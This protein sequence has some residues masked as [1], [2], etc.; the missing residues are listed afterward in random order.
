MS[1]TVAPPVHP[2]LGVIYPI[3]DEAR[4]HRARHVMAI[5]R[6][7]LGWTFLWAFLDK[8]FGFGYATE[9]ADA[10]LN[11]GSPTFGFLNFATEGKTFHTFFAGLSG[12]TADWLF[13]VGLL[14]IGVA[15]ILGIGMR[16]AAVSGVLLLLS[17]WAAGLP[18]ANNPITDSHIVDAV[19]IVALAVFGAG[20]TWGFGRAW[21]AL[22]IVHRLPFLR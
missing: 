7:V 1:T 2:E 18:L 12:T 16:I 5:A 4:A 20:R 11:G 6:I 9:R 21:E 10:W 8:A 19:V 13:M 22:P 17:M 14:G 15:L 3:E